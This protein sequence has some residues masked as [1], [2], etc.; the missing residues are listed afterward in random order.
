MMQWPDFM[1][2]PQLGGYG[3]QPQKATERTPMSAGPARVRRRFTRV[4]TFI[5]QTWIL[6][7]DQFGMF[8]WWVENSIDGGAAWWIGQQKNGTGL[9]QVPCRFIEKDGGPYQAKALGGDLWEVTAM[10][11]VEYMPKGK[12][13][14][15]W[16]ADEPTLDLDFLAQ[17]YGVAG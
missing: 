17:T 3:L 4:P 15:F 2:A 9:V 10:V 1:P 14:D 7:A 5:P 16:P 13:T 6:T 11:E 12:L 8:E